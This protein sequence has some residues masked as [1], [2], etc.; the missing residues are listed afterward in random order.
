MKTFVLSRLAAMV[1]ILV[2]L[3][4]VLFVL[5]HISPVDPVHAQLG[6]Q[7]SADAIAARKHALG[8]D[9]PLLN[10]FWHYLT[11]AVHGDLGT[12]YRTRR[13]VGTDLGAFVPA[14]LELALYGIA[15]ALV[16]AA[17]MA[18][19]TTLKWRGSGALRAVLFAG[20][21][22]PMFLLGILGLIVFYQRL[23]WVPANGRSA[24]ADPPTGPTGLLTVDGLLAG[25]FDVVTDAWHHLILPAIVIAIGPAVAIG[26]VLR[27]SLLTD[28]D[29]D[30]ARTARA[31]GLSEIRIVAG[32]VLRNCVGAALSMTGLQ[33]CLML[34]GVLVVEQVFGWPGIGQY[35]AQS[36]PVA[37]F[38][39]IAGV[40]LMLGALYVAINTAVDL[41]Q[42][43]ADPR[44]AT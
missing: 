11:G 26:R 21:S 16:L 20:A 9:Q 43:A 22:A 14:T 30:Y 18:F 10:Q 42:A 44:I 34:S 8:L 27:S 36:I 40:T 28:I 37:D 2:A 33:V 1:A 6:A 15:I 19:G 7:A 13:P 32:H 5:Q 39:A 38:P 31:K 41:L 24:V 3:T 4:A 29:S 23:G 25:R 35:I 17:L 12:S